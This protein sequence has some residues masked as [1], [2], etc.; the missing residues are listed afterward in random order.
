MTKSPPDRRADLPGRP[1]GKIQIN[2]AAIGL[3]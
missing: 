1:A 3:I 2:I